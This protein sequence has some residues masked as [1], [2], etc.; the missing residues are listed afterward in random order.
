M[1]EQN[2]LDVAAALEFP[3]VEDALTDQ[4]A[5]DAGEDPALSPQ[6]ALSGEMMEVSDG[7]E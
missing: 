1:E 7:R 4:D 3:F 2:N 6:E 5:A